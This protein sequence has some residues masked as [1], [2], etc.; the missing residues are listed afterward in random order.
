MVEVVERG[1]DV[2]AVEL[3][4]IDLLGAVIEARG[5]AQADRVR[6]REQAEPLVRAD[7]AVLVQ[8]GQA[9][10]RLQHALD[11][12]HDVRATRVV[13]VEHQG[14]RALQRPGQN[15]F[16]ELGDLLAVLDHDGVLADQVDAADVA[17]QVDADQGPVEAG[18]DLLDVGRLAGAV[19][20]LDHDAAVVGEARADGDRGL[21]IETIAVVDLR[22]MAVARVEGRNDHVG[23]D[24]ER[25]SQRDLAVRF[26]GDERVGGGVERRGHGQS[27]YRS[28][29]GWSRPSPI[30]AILST[31]A[32]AH[33]TLR[34]T[35]TLPR[36]ALE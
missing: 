26:Q 32:M 16:A 21:G 1:D 31:A 18:G 34:V 29:T 28:R 25:L 30:R 17:V 33:S 14:D 24:A 11:H 5:V 10:L 36:V 3:G 12:E 4:L 22:H 6:G 15:A 19:I 9:A 8:Q 2:P 20:A 27:D 23:I 35:S 13:F 7:D